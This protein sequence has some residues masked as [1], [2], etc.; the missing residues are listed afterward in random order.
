MI[1]KTVKASDLKFNRGSLKTLI[2]QRAD[3]FAFVRSC[4][5]TEPIVLLRLMILMVSLN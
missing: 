2:A 5:F 3:S 1:I 4:A